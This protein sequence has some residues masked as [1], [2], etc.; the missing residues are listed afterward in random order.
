MCHLVSFLLVI[1][2]AIIYHLLL[3]VDSNKL[4]EEWHVLHTNR[5]QS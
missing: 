2:T 1:F 3:L 5:S 4:R